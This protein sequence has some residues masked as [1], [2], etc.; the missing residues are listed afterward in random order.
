M[1]SYREEASKALKHILSLPESIDSIISLPPSGLMM[2]YWRVVKKTPGTTI[3]IK[4]LP[5]NILERITFYNIDSKKYEKHLTDKEKRLY[6][7]EIKKD[8]TYFSK[9]HDRADFQVDIQGLD[10]EIA[11]KKI[12]ELIESDQKSKQILCQKEDEHK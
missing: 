9:S 11:A 7:K 3:V 4:D 2:G 1:Y 5:E 12:A 8:I 10:P 6:L